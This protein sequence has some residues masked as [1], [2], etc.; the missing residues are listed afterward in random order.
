MTDPRPLVSLLLALASLCAQ[1]PV[2]SPAP[3]RRTLGDLDKIEWLRPLA[4]AREVAR[5]QGRVV[6][7]KPILGGSN[8]PAP[9]GVPCGGKN[10]CEGSW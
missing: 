1:E 3:D 8:T 7:V 9:D 2:P 4:H 5:Q 6:L 10:D